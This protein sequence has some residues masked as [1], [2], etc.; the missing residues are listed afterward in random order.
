MILHR[1][2]HFYFN[3]LSLAWQLIE[4]YTSVPRIERVK[5][6]CSALPCKAKRRYLLTLQ[7]RRYCILTLQNSIGI[8]DRS[9]P[10]SISMYYST[11]E[12]IENYKSSFLCYQL[13]ILICKAKRKYLSFG[14]AGENRVQCHWYSRVC[15]WATGLIN[16]LRPLRWPSGYTA[17][18]IRPI[19]L[20]VGGSIPGWEVTRLLHILWKV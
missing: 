9:M 8:C 12:A 16:I 7:I 10:L 11:D 1:V 15:L 17:N 4:I 18:T 6:C 20:R 5:Y 2:F 14:F 19:S 3:D 13:D